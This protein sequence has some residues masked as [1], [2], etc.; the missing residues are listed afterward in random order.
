MSMLTAFNDHFIEF[1]GDI[2]SVFPDDKDILIAKNAFLTIR[3]AN[4]KLIIKIW[5]TYIVS[6]YSAEIE[7]GE[8]D[9]FINKDY[10]SDLASADNSQKI[11]EAIDRL[12]NPVKAMTIQDQEKTMKYIQNLT[13][14][15]TLYKQTTGF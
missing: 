10:S 2:H 3:K 6:K 4:P 12:R 13:K 9:F 5:D 7:S 14:L 15:A 11:I 1:V 8:I